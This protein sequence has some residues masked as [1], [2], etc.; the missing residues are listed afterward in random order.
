[1]RL[2]SIGKYA[3]KFSLLKF[4]LHGE[5]RNT[6]NAVIKNGQLLERFTA[7]GL[8]MGLDRNTFSVFGHQWPYVKR[9]RI[10][11]AKAFMLLQLT[12]V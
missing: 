12:R 9:F 1:M 11:E 10:S 8:Q 3:N 2:N 7:V 4:F 5:F 6:N